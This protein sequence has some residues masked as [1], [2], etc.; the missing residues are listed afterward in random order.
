MNSDPTIIEG[1]GGTRETPGGA[2]VTIIEHPAGAARTLIETITSAPPG[3]IHDVNLTPGGTFLGCQLFERI[4]VASGEAELWFACQ[5]DGRPAVLKL[6]NWGLRPKAEL[7]AKLSAVSRRHVVDVYAQGLAPDGRHYELLERIQHGSLADLAQ[8]GLAEPRLREVLAELTDAVAALHAGDILHRDLKPANILVRTLA[9]LDLVLTDFGISSVAQL[10]LHVTGVQRTA[11]YGAPE[12]MTGVVS[13]AS[14]WWSVG[15]IVL[16]LLQRRHPFAG[17]DERAVNFTLVTRGIEV[18]ATLAAE[19]Q[20]LL[21]GLLTRDHAHRWGAEQVKAWLAGRRDLPVH[22]RGPAEEIASHRAAHKPYKFCGKEYLTSEE[23]A[24]ALGGN[25]V[26]GA[27]QFSRGMIREW[28]ATQVYDQQLTSTLTDVA[29]DKKLDADMKLAVALL[30]L[31]PQLPLTWKGEVVGPEWLPDNV[32]TATAILGGTLPEWMAQLRSNRGLLDLRAW[33]DQ[34]LARVK[35][36]NVACDSSLV[37]RLAL[38]TREAVMA[39]GTEML[40]AYAGSTDPG[41]DHLFRRE[42]LTPEEAI[43]LAT[44]A[45][46]LLLTP[47]QKRL[48]DGMTYLRGFGVPMDW[49]VAETLLREENVEAALTQFAAALR[50]WPQR[51]RSHQRLE[52]LRGA[53]EMT[54]PNLVAVIAAFVPAHAVEE[55]ERLAEEKCQRQAEERRLK[56]LGAE[57]QEA[58][59]HRNFWFTILGFIAFPVIMFGLVFWSVDVDSKEHA[60]VQRLEAERKQIEAVA[61]AE[62]DAKV[63]AEAEV[64]AKVQAEAEAKARAAREAETQAE[65]LQ[66]A[67]AMKESPGGNSLGMKFVPV[68]GTP[69]WFSVWD[70]RVRDY[71]AFASATGRRVEKPFFEQAPAHPVVNV[72]WDDAQAFAKWLTEKERREGKIPATLSYRLPQDWEWSVAVGLNEARGGTPESKDRK[73]KN[74]Y[75]W[76]TQWP[77]PR[78]AGNYGKSLNVHGYEYTSPV[79]SFAA[80]RFGLY[81]MGG[82]VWQWCED[83]F[84]GSSGDR[85]LRGGSWSSDDS[86][87]LLSSFRRRCTADARAYNIGFRCVLVG[88]SSR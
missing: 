38:S 67:A 83:F 69:V 34:V 40:T 50:D 26:E 88:V 16:E 27:K 64:K 57:R 78:G 25:W 86:E 15:V 10:T 36:A 13:Q 85:V 17:L 31:H 9:P 73:I 72:S 46:E 45:R 62:T 29:E 75:P 79:G 76:G 66:I 20:L 58:R 37:D 22:Y 18:P 87:Y 6:Y 24:V 42:A 11:A 5:P 8:S 55:R 4:K 35:A 3:A 56:Q 81:N 30:A 52:E 41:L 23:L 53:L 44:C 70:T 19:W 74:V 43:L 65:A 82:N 28:V 48:V 77:P 71:A 59:R 33:R 7:G 63:R 12:A 68:A 80:N 39:V 32:P 2:A 21:K 47:P 14:D 51:L 61:Q 84:D 54:F 60:R 1:G 49:K